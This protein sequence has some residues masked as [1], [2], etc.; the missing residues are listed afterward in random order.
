MPPN[1]FWSARPGLLTPWPAAVG[2]ATCTSSCPAEL[3][4]EFAPVQDSMVTSLAR[5]VRQFF[6]STRESGGFPERR[7]F[8][9]HAGETG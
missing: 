5:A 4:N 2:R 7:G 1:D 6:A 8:G 3:Q 9:A